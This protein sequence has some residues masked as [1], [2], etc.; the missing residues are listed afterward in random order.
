[1]LNNLLHR[2]SMPLAGNTPGIVFENY[3][4][5]SKAAGSTKNHSNIID[6][7]CHIKHRR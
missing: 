3:I 2:K 7:A 1:M 6:E 4:I 5:Y